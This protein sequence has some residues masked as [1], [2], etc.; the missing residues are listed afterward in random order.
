MLYF[1]GVMPN[2]Y[3][4]V[5]DKNHFSGS[6]RPGQRLNFAQVRAGPEHQPQGVAVEASSGSRTGLTPGGW[7][8]IPSAPLR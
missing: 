7:Y 8:P 2:F 3:N 4:N 5:P 6:H 1:S